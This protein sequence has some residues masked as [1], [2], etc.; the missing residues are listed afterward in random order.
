MKVFLSWSGSSSRSVAVALRS[1]L[2]D[3]F[4]DIEPWMS[5]EDIAAGAKWNAALDEELDASKSGVLCLTREN[6]NSK[7]LMFEAGRLS[8]SSTITRVVPFLF[9][10]SPVDIGPPLGQFQGVTA[11]ETGAFQLAQSLNALRESPY[12]EEKLARATARWLPDLMASLAAVP[13]SE[14]A[15]ANSSRT[16]R[17]V[18]EELLA[19]VRELRTEAPHGVMRAQLDLRRVFGLIERIERMTPEELDDA[20][21]VA[22][23]A[24]R[25]AGEDSIRAA[26]GQFFLDVA[27]HWL[28]LGKSTHPN[29]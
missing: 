19:S 17:D 11:N 16:D 9:R 22:E 15:N 24:E 12:T 10:L 7:W 3:V 29:R 21:H 18:L 25:L 28:A 26:N 8:K 13:T 27:T 2:S 14:D 5:A 23:R 1:W 20:I 4:P 6:L